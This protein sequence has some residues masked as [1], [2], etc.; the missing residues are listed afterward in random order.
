MKDVFY[1]MLEKNVRN[2]VKEIFF[3]LTIQSSPHVTLPKIYVYFIRLNEK[4]IGTMFCLFGGGFLSVYSCFSTLRLTG[5]LLGLKFN[6]VESDEGMEE[7][8]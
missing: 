3:L 7:L 2:D 8:I 5:L 6:A 4:L 1:I